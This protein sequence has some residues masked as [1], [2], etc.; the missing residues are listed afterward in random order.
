[1]PWQ[2]PLLSD[3]RNQVAQDIA[4][5]IPGSDPLLRFSNLGILGNVQAG[6]AH[7]HYGYLD[8]IALQSNPFTA[9]G[10]YLEAWAAL[11]DVFREA[12]TSASGQITFQAT[13]SD[14]L[15]PAGT[16]ITRGDGVSCTTTADATATSGGAVIVQATMDADPTGLTG[17]FGNTATGVT[18]TLGM[19]IPGVKS[20]GTVT[21][22][23]TGGAD[24]ETDDSLRSRML[25]EYQKSPQGGAKADYEIWAREVPGVTRSWCNPLGAGSGT[26]VTYIMLDSVESAFNGFPQG[27]NGVAAGESRDVPA[28]GDQLTVANYIYALRPATAL[29]Y[30]V[31]PVALPVNFTITGLSSASSS[32]QAAI[33]QAISG[34]LQQTGTPLGGT[35][36]LSLIESAIASVPG[37]AGF[38][39][40]SP[41]GNITTT[42]GQLP[43][44]GAITYA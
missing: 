19:A 14:A 35:V 31:A 11:K 7:L 16:P 20:S 36:D 38:V 40:T 32:T 2:R 26:V 8:W 22:A 33:S 39:I 13:P 29:V 1:M 6:L 10:E 9:T 28:T 18:M 5:A 3:L 30:I 23:F 21:T 27:T 4:S 12:A 44:L 34:V 43:V 41:S 17:A 37:T 25:E 15:I 42:I 24:L